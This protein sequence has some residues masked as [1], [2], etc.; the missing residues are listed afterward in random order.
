MKPKNCLLLIAIVVCHNVD[1]YCQ[2]A[3][4]NFAFENGESKFR[5][6][7]CSTTFVILLLC[8]VYFN[9]TDVGKCATSQM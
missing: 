8:C 2:D 3:A 5:I 6:I 4:D 1:N 7:T 9:N